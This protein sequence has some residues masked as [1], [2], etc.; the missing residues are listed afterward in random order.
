M[1]GRCYYTLGE[2]NEL[3][4]ISESV[5]EKEIHE[6]KLKAEKLGRK[7][8]VILSEL[9]KYL[10]PEKFEDFFNNRYLSEEKIFHIAGV[11]R[12]DWKNTLILQSPDWDY[13]LVFTKQ[14]DT[15]GEMAKVGL[16]CECKQERETITSE[17]FISLLQS[18]QITSV[19][20][21]E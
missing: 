10:N 2:L 15:P 18:N 5:L 9:K 12:E 13:V 19:S 20:R 17:R 7:Y 6:N 16:D 8:R 4:G 14:P 11:P 3:T 21:Y 1:R